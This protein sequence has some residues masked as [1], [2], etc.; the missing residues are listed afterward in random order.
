MSHRAAGPLGWWIAALLLLA[1]TGG[2]V[3]AVTTGDRESAAWLAMGAWVLLLGLVVPRTA[4][5]Q[6]A[7]LLALI[8]VGC[9]AS[10]VGFFLL[11]NWAGWRV[12]AY[13]DAISTAAISLQAAVVIWI[14]WSRPSPEPDH[15]EGRGE[16]EAVPRD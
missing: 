13:I 16:P 11:Y 15:A 6:P 12:M 14:K 10:A 2:L 5:E 7:W 1:V 9:G 4:P 8:A 3:W